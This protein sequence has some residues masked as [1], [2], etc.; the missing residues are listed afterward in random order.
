[1]SSITPKIWLYGEWLELKPR[2]LWVCPNGFAAVTYKGRIRRVCDDF[3]ILQDSE[4]TFEKDQ[5]SFFK[6]LYEDLKFVNTKQKINATPQE[7]EQETQDPF[8]GALELQKKRTLTVKIHHNHLAI[9]ASLGV[10]RAIHALTQQSS[11]AAQN[12]LRTAIKFRPRFEKTILLDDK[13]VEAQSQ[14]L[15]ILDKEFLKLP[16]KYFVAP[17]GRG[18]FS[19]LPQKLDRSITN[20]DILNIINSSEDPP[21]LLRVRNFK[22]QA[23][24]SLVFHNEVLRNY[25]NTS[26]ERDVSSS[27]IEDSNVA[28]FVSDNKEKVQ[29]VIKNNLKLLENN[30]LTLAVSRCSN[31]AKVRLSGWQESTFETFYTLATRMPRHLKLSEKQIDLLSPEYPLLVKKL[32]IFALFSTTKSQFLQKKY[33]QLHECGIKNVSDLILMHPDLFRLFFRK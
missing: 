11:K 15:M 30:E 23:T 24:A 17:I 27:I 18:D 3:S 2:P 20:H 4:N 19:R 7:H 28:N 14:A 16:F 6:G 25:N 13:I 8:S 31:R 32:S 26:L 33:I 29:G 12:V 1:M 5:C 10:D 21:D 22:A 9:L